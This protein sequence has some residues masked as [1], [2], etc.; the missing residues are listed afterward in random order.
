MLKSPLKQ[1]RKRV[2]TWLGITPPKDRSLGVIDALEN[3]QLRGWFISRLPG[4][5]GNRFMLFMDD[6]ALGTFDALLPR[7]DLLQAEGV[8]HCGFQVDLKPLLEAQPHGLHALH[9]GQ[10]HRLVLRTVRGRTLADKTVTGRSP[11]RGFLDKLDATGLHGWAIDESAPGQ[12]VELS[13]YVDDV[14]YMDLK[15]TLARSD[16]VSKGLPGERA[17]FSQIWPAGLLKPGSTVDIRYKHSGESLSKSPRQLAGSAVPS[18]RATLGYLD[19]WH[20]QHMRPVTVIVPIYNAFDAVSECLESLKRTMPPEARVLLINDASPDPRIAELLAGLTGQTGF[21]VVTNET[22]LGYTRTVNKAIGLCPANDV[23]LLNSD[24]V[25]TNR[26]LENLRYAAY[27]QPR[28]ATVTA[29]SDHAGAFSAPEI[30]AFN[31]VSPHLD[32]D[33][34]ARLIVQA[35]EGRLL[36]VPTGNGFCMYMRRSA[37]DAL[38]TFDEQKFPRGYGEEND[39]CMRAVRRGWVNLV[40]D[41]VYVFHKRSQSFQGEKEA[42]MRAGAEQLA[43]DYPEY[44]LLTQR[45]SDAEFA[46]VR[47]LARTATTKGS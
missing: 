23:V 43:T 26:W 10:S 4:A 20:T 16:L 41:K 14:H 5:E 31:P 6:V 47:Y 30:G 32:R 40:C 18:T 36:E 12:S 13:M 37:I 45:F 15:T 29:M 46:H 35:Q 33:T 3:D 1:A 7:E 44:R 27:S 21:D 39:F 24:T 22:N 2:N 34:H 28:V 9:D 8:L 25:T 11:M 42:L 38:G 19:A 17:G